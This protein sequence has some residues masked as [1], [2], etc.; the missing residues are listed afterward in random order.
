MLPTMY[1]IDYNDIL[2]SSYTIQYNTYGDTFD[3]N[4]IGGPKVK[5]NFDSLSN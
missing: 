1:K 5:N 2:H 4:I 3:Q